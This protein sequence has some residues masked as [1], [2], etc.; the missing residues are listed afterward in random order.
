MNVSQLKTSSVEEQFLSFS[1]A[2]HIK[3]LMSISQMSEV[4]TINLEQILRMPHMKPWVMGVYNWRGE[5]LWMVDLG[6]LLGFPPL[7]QERNVRSSYK[8]IVLHLPLKKYDPA[9]DRTL[10]L[11][12]S[13]IEDIEWCNS[14]S[15]ESPP[16][17]TDN[18][19]MPFLRGYYLPNDRE[20]LA[21]FEGESILAAMSN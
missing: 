11:V 17:S 16:P 8:A 7:H 3:G 19:L 13:Q 6:K 10:G 5:I 18:K 9:P 14:I 21:V 20:A 4:L 1:F 2:S 15:I 12:V